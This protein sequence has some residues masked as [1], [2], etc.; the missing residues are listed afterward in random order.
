MQ[1]A[2]RAVALRYDTQ[3]DLA[4]RVV[5]KGAEAVANA[6][7]RTAE[8]HRVPVVEQTELVDALFA[9][10]VDQ[11]IPPELYQAVAEILAYIYRYRRT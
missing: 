7:V 10:E 2:K 8:G 3:K 9:L 6:I 5:A 4:P 11:V 1:R